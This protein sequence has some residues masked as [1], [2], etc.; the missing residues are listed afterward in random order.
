[1]YKF[2]IAVMLSLV[3]MTGCAKKNI[4]KSV[5]TGWVVHNSL[6]RTA[7]ELGKV[8]TL[9]LSDLD[10]FASYQAPAKEGLDAATEDLLDGDD[11]FSQAELY[12]DLIGP[13]LERMVEITENK[14]E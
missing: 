7:T 12:L 10:E 9:D 3:V 14:D 2:L 4:A 11:D 13:M 1:M 5:G 8:G 6:T